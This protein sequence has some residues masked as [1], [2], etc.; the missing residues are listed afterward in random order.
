MEEK[1][2]EVGLAK[3]GPASSSITKTPTK[4]NK[5]DEAQLAAESDDED[6]GANDTESFDKDAEYAVG[7][8]RFQVDQEDEVKSDDSSD[9]EKKEPKGSIRRMIMDL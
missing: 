1:S 5:L 8:G 3:Y 6:A 7:K 2:Y 4:A 9:L